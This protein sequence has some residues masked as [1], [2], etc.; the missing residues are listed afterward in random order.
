MMPSINNIFPSRYLKAHELQGKEPVVTIAKV[1]LEAMGRSR[2]VCPVVYFRDKAKGLKLNITMARA[3]AAIA[4]SDDTDH[5]TGTVVQLF[6]TTDE[7]ATKTF[8]VVRIKAPLRSA[9]RRIA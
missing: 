3:I 7:F 4:G 5:W 8:P 6:A 1:A 2:D 9:P